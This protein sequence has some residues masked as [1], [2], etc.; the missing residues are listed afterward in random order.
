MNHALV[1]PSTAGESHRIDFFGPEAVLRDVVSGARVAVLG[2]AADST[3]VASSESWRRTLLAQLV[4]QPGPVLLGLGLAV[5]AGCG[6]DRLHPPAKLLEAA[7]ARALSLIGG[8]LGIVLVAAGTLIL[9][10]RH[11]H[12]LVAL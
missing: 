7:A 1:L 9:V 6:P 2:L 5:M 4:R 10:L 11:P 3:T 8:A 12:L